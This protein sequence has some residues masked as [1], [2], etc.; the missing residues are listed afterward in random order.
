MITKREVILVLI[1]FSL[2]VG[3]AFLFLSRE[4]KQTNE[5]PVAVLNNCMSRVK[6]TN[7]LVQNCSTAYSI[8]SACVSKENSCDIKSSTN[9]LKRL[10]EE[11]KIIELKLKAISEELSTITQES[12]L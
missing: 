8:I 12:N 11:K 7:D 5:I 6:S 4:G 1:A 9:E 3:L 10:N 2:G